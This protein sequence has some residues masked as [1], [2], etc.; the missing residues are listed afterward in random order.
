MKKIFKALSCV[1]AISFV[2][3]TISSCDQEYSSIES[4]VLGEGNF[5]FNSNQ[6][7]IPI[8]T[9]NQNLSGQQ[10]NGLTSQLLGYFND[11]IYGETTAS[12]VSQ[13]SPTSFLEIDNTFGVNPII[14][15][16]ELTIPYFSTQIS[17]DADGKPGYKI[18]SLF[19]T[20]NN[21]DNAKAIRLSVYQNNYFLRNFS[22]NGDDSENYYS[23]ADGA[24]NSTDNF[25]EIQNDII[26]FDEHLG[27]QLYNGIYEFDNE[28]RAQTTTSNDVETTTY[29]PPAIVLDLTEIDGSK[30]FWKTLILDQEGQPALSNANNFL[31]HFRGLYIKAQAINNEGSMVL[32]NLVESGANIVINYSSDDNDDADTERETGTY[33]LNFTGN[34]LNTFINNYNSILPATPDVTN[35]DEKLFLKG[36]E[37]SMAVIELFSGLVDCDG[38]GQVNDNALDCFKN[39][40]RKTDE[41]GNVLEPINELYQLKRLVNE[42][43]LV[44]YEDESFIKPSDPKDPNGEDYHTYDRLYIYN[45]ETNTPI[46]DYNS[47]VTVEATS[48]LISRRFSLGRRIVDDEGNAKYKIKIT[49]LLNNILVR[50]LDLTKLGLVL[51]N[52]VNISTN[53]ELLN[54]T[55]DVTGVPSTA[56]LAPRGTVLHGSNSSDDNKKMHLEVFFTE[57]K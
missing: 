24:I 10:I 37:G 30:D 13:V 31:N 22:L 42:A 2:V 11:P 56:I 25:S 38:D 33:T 14:E 26:N 4:G 54:D 51:T 19:V 9:Y 12:I 21:P 50:D 3:L 29:L 55:D 43:N 8:T 35:G 46:Q 36:T 39:T 53:T 57:S 23:K 44:I 34:L 6:L 27:F 18:D 16:V 17:V 5:N 45:L 15:S 40:F 47:D 52:N 32:L 28:P 48:P 20:D 7:E 41:N 1:I 49:D